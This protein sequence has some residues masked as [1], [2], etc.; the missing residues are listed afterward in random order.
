[1]IKRMAAL[2]LTTTI[3]GLIPAFGTEMYPFFL[4]RQDGSILEGYFSPPSSENLPIVV[5]IQGSSSESVLPWHASISD[6]VSLF[7]FGVISLEKQGISQGGMDVFTYHQTNCLQQREDDYALC[8][9]NIS[10]IYPDWEG[11]MIFWGAS[12]GG[13]IAAHLAGGTENTAALALFGA[14]GGMTP[15]EEVLWTIQ[16]RLQEQRAM[17]EEVDEYMHFLDQQMDLMLSDPTPEKQFLGNT[18]KWWASFLSAEQAATLLSQRAIPICLVHGVEDI[19]IPVQSAD[20]T[21]DVLSKT[22]ALTYL[23][24]EGYGHDLDTLPVQEAVCR[25][26]SAV[27]LGQKSTDM[28]IAQVTRPVSTASHFDIAHYVFSRGKDKGE[29]DK[30][31]GKGEVYGSV[32]GER[33]TEGREKATVDIGGSY[34]SDSGWRAEGIAGA[35]VS[36]DKDGNTKGEVHAEAKL[37]R[38]F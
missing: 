29:E 15:R 23:R 5:A 14:G 36:R 11:K 31:G 12:E 35:S 16:H 37:G 2:F 22:N 38:E 4:Q 13:M 17:Q 21:A 27:L 30:G 34:K 8:L 20:L 9:K 18:Y 26:L 6:Q 7:G 10:L 1:M 32:R 3:C 25:W 24:L 19:Q 33:D 28:S